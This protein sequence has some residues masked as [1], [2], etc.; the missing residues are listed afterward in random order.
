M[1]LYVSCFGVEFIKEISKIN[2]ESKT[3]C[4]YLFFLR[5]LL[6]TCSMT[7]HKLADQYCNF[8]YQEV[9]VRL[10]SRLFAL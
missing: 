5:G 4:F 3:S 2:S 10:S 6:L 1:V 8:Q 9:I 7:Q